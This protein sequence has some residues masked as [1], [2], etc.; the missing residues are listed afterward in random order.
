LKKDIEKEK[1]EI[2]TVSSLEKVKHFIK[3]HVS[4]YNWQAAKFQ[5]HDRN[6][7]GRIEFDERLD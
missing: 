6:L 1:T 2:H 3:R 7:I 4:I 5:I